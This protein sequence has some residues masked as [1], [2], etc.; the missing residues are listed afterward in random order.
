MDKKCEMDVILG[1]LPWG[2]KLFPFHGPVK[3]DEAGEPRS[4][5]KGVLASCLSTPAAHGQFCCVYVSSV[6]QDSPETMISKIPFNS[7][8]R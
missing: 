8:K 6:K 2:D 3:W 4:E 7:Y 5:L 1:W